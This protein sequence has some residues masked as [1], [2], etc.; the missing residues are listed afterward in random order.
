MADGHEL[1]RIKHQYP[2]GLAHDG[3]SL[4]MFQGGG[5]RFDTFPDHVF[6]VMAKAQFLQPFQHG[7]GA[8]AAIVGVDEDIGEADSQM[9]REPFQ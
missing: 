2:I 8:V 4:G 6:A 3:L 7:I 5:V 1:I 9:M